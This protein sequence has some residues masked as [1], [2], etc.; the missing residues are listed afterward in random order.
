MRQHLVRAEAACQLR[1][2]G[3]AR[4]HSDRRLGVQ[5][6]Q[7][8]DRAQSEGTRSVDE[9]PS[10]GRWRMPGD[11]VQRNR[12]RVGEHRDLV[13]H[14]IRHG[15][16]H[17]VVGRHQFGVAAGDVRR[18]PGVDARLDVAVGEAPAQAVIPGFA[19]RTTGFDAAWSA[20]QP[21]VEDDPL[22]DLQSAGGRTQCHHVGHDFVS[23]HLGERAE[24]CHR[25]VGV[26]LAEVEQDLLGVRAADPCQPR[27]G[28][29]PIIVQR[30]RIRHI[31]QA[32]G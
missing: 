31:L 20:R 24:R 3:E 29:H 26:T 11:R 30:L 2:G 16:Q 7:H 5:R 13:G 1:L 15:E 21:W 6:T 12:E 28:D 27:P 8:R 18:H 4:H 9:H 25:V 14:R 32:D 19:C 22:P 10:R 23:H 17:A